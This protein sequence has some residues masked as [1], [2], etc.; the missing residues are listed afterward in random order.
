MRNKILNSISDIVVDFTVLY[1]KKTI[2]YAAA[3]D[4]RR[5]ALVYSLTPRGGHT[6]TAR[7]TVRHP[8]PP[9]TTRLDAR[10]PS[11][12]LLS[13]ARPRASPRAR[14][15]RCPERIDPRE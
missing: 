7:T 15:D 10:W 1:R 11:L 12:A 14:L 2:R 6:S 5:R 8:S 13:P 4:S 3:R 9:P